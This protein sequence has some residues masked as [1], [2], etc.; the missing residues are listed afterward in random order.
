MEN[1]AIIG[2]AGYIA[3]RHLKA[4]K[5]TGNRIIAVLDP[6]DSVGLLDQYSYSIDYF[7][8]TER[9]ERYLQ[10][11]RHTH[12]QDQVGWVSICSPNYLH[13]AHCRLAMEVGANVI[14][15]K[16]LVINPW[17]LDMLEDMERRY[18]RRVFT[19]LQ[20]RLHPELLK[21]HDQLFVKNNQGAKHDVQ[22]RYIT[23]RGHWYHE[24][25]KGNEDKSGGLITNIGVHL[26]DMLIWLFGMPEVVS[27]HRKSDKTIRGYLDMEHA[28]VEWFLSIDKNQ[29]T[30][31]EE[32]AG[33]PVRSLVIDGQTTNFADGFTD[34]HTKVYEEILKGNGF[35]ISDA[36]PAIELTHKIRKIS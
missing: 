7:S 21:L 35:G 36:R 18:E 26:F 13:D 15:E 27:V 17:N 12:S 10:R 25:W 5:E 31:E 34:L 2:A 24:S 4:I 23:P 22:L 6:H 1:F 20:L 8:E 19:V 32:T 30:N 11:L 14:C 3:P 29:W 28:S 9:F 33:K 16:P